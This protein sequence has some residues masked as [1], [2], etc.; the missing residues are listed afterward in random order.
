MKYTTL[1]TTRCSSC[2]DGL[3]TLE[4]RLATVRQRIAHLTACKPIY[5]SRGRS[6]ACNQSDSQMRADLPA[7]TSEMIFI[8]L[9]KYLA[10]SKE[11]RSASDRE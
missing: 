2:W 9:L 1:P 10:L 5:F 6:L 7:K 3:A 8:N 11:S 4:I